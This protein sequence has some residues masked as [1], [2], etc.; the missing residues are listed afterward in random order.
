MIILFDLTSKQIVQNILVAT[1]PW[2]K[3]LEIAHDKRLKKAIPR[4]S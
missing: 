2:E 3:K 1:R 4:V